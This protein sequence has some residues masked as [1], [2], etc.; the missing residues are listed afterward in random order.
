MF[1]YVILLAIVYMHSTASPVPEAKPDPK[2]H[3]VAY[4][5]PVVVAEPSFADYAVPVA[6]TADYVAPAFYSSGYTAYAPAY[7]AYSAPL[8]VA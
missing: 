7:A 6:Y 3:V 2:A 8:I 4:S 5:S 1:K